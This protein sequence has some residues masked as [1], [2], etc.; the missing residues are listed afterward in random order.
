M[1]YRAHAKINV[2]L[3]ITG[4]RDD[5]YHDIETIFMPLKEPHDIIAIKELKGN[6]PV[7]LSDNTD[8]PLDENNLCFKAAVKFAEFADITPGW[9]ID[10]QK[11]IPIAAGLGGGSSD[12]AAVL[13]ILNSMYPVLDKNVIFD[14]ASSLGADV[15]FFLDPKP[16][17]ASGIGNVLSPLTG[18][19]PLNL[20]ILNPLFPLS[21]AW[22]YE[23]YIPYADG[24]TLEKVVSVLQAGDISRLERVFCNDLQMAV[25]QKFPIMGILKNDL[26]DAGAVFVG[27]SGSGPSLFAVCSSMKN[28]VEVA[29][30]MNVKYKN[31]IYCIASS[32]F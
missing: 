15:P 26:L 10:I 6:M 18:L 24:G 17:S 20:V 11:N 14:I 8:M 27:M 23:H 32:T 31:A 30:I 22:G 25:F 1:T 7:I 28:A 3:K 9:Q 21:A 16:A 2:F 12:A 4:K 29:Q 19:E 13:N 5:S